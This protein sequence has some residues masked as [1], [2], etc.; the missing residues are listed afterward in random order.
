MARDTNF[1]YSFLVLTPARRQAIVAV[2][3]FCR[4]VDDAVDEASTETE[5]ER[6]AAA[7][8]LD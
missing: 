2:W 8:P 1:Y 7:A 4:A 3:D 5:E 6:A